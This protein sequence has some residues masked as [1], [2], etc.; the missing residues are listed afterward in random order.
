MVAKKG[1][2][3]ACPDFNW[4]NVFAENGKMGREEHFKKHKK[5]QNKTKTKAH[6]LKKK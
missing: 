1:K 4:K 6:A 3:K 2:I 5:T